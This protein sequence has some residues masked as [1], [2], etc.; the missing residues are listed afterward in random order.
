MKWCR[1]R[2]IEDPD[3]GELQRAAVDAAA[4]DGGLRVLGRPGSRGAVRGPGAAARLRGR[5]HRHRLRHHLLQV[6]SARHAIHLQFDVSANAL[7]IRAYVDC[8]LHKSR[9]TREN[10]AKAK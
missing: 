9:Y 2:I 8:T 1:Q 7:K 6:R 4:T 3:P 10:V 5:L